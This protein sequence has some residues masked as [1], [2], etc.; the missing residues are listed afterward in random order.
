MQCKRNWKI[1]FLIVLIGTQMGLSA[2]VAE[3]LDTQLVER[4]EYVVKIGGCND[5][6][7]PDYLLS[8]GK[9]PKKLWLTGSALGWRGPWGTTY[10]PNLRILLEDLSEKEWLER[11]KNLKTRP[12]MPWYVLNEMKEDDLRAIYQ[13]IR[14]MGPE[15][16]PAPQ[17]VPPGKEPTT[18]YALFPSPPS[19]KDD[20]VTK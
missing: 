4:G 20:N 14:S 6:H 11:A 18:P 12:P 15:G 8:G 9:T 7:T 13:F 16:K 19:S 10:S 1:D 2:T 5:C 3:S 17:Y